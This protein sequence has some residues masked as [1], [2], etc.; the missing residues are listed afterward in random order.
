MYDDRSPALIARCADACDVAAALAHARSAGL[1]V[2]VRGGGHHVAGFATRDG[3]IVIDLT[4]MAAVYVDPARRAVRVEGGV[5]WGQLDAATQEYGLAVTGGREP[6]T[7]VMGQALGSGSGWLERSLGLTC[8]SLIAAELVTADGR[9]VRAS[10]HEHPD[11]FWAVR[12]AGANFGV[13]TAIELRLHPVGPIVLG[14]L[15]MFP[16]ER[17]EEV[18]A[19]WRDLNESGPDEF[20]SCLVVATAPPDPNLPPDVQGRPF[21][22]LAVCH[23]GSLDE[24]R[25][26]VER[27]YAAVPPLIDGIEPM[28]YTSAQKLIEPFAGRGLRQYWRAENLP[29][30]SD[31]A[32][33]ELLDH[34]THPASPLSQV[35]VEPKGRA[36]ARVDPDFTALTGRDG[37]Y[38]WYAFSLWEDEA[39]DDA[40]IAWARALTDRMRPYSIAG[41]SPNFIE[42][43]GSERL[44]SIFGDAK[45]ERL[46]ALKRE[47]DPDNVFNSNQNVDP[48]R[49]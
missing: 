9:L 21:V 15:A 18:F 35:V 13:V 45:Y 23:S 20:G 39:D 41:I 28:P 14:G 16:A 8:D 6:S 11:L 1:E 46:V 7:G 33:A 19:A 36:I 29:A 17:G 34:G 12:G 31:G 40:G 25:A 44:R 27:L 4:E 42:R 49:P 43:A 5:K 37:E 32:I 26:L 30:L 2:A 24:G 47:W 22:G 10:A 3:A 38:H 48:D